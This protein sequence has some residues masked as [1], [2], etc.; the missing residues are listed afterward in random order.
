ME[1]YE[2]YWKDTMIGVLS[3]NEEQHKYEH[4]EEAIQKLKQIP[5]DPAVTRSRDWGE[6]IP[7]FSSRLESC[8]RFP[9][10]EIGFQTDFY[11]FKR[12]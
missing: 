1:K 2:V 8:K 6:K 3:V 11:R 10:L 9:E 4:I 5:F 12:I 7:F